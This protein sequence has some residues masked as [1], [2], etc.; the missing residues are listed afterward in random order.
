V[1]LD[2]N[3]VKVP[4]A[5]GLGVTLDEDKIKKLRVDI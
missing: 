3:K 4:D 2:G 1:R 5:P